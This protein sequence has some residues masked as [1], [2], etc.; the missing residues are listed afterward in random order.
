VSRTGRPLS[1]LHL[2]TFYPPYSFGGDAMYIYRLAHALGDE[3]HHVEV[4]HCLD[5]YHLLHPG[6]PPVG[7]PGHPN[8]V[9]HPL[10]SGWGP[11]SPLASHQSGRPWLK[12]QALRRVLDSRP[13]DVV[14]FHNISLL[15]PRVL[16]LAPAAGRPVKL[17]TT[18]EHWLICPTHVLWK[19]N[20]RPCERPACL[21]CTLMA[22]R[23]PQLWRYTG[24]L[25]REAAHVDRFLAP[26]RFTARMHAERGFPR[27]V[28]HLPYFVDRADED[29][30]SPGPRPHPAPY[31]LF[32]GRLELIKGLQTLIEAFRTVRGADLLVAGTG[33]YEPAL[34]AMAAG[35]PRIRFLGAVPPR[36]LGRLYTH[37]LACVVPSLTIETFGIIIIEAFAR[38]TPVIARD[39]GAL[40]EVVHDSD[41]GLLFR[42]DDELRAALE[43]ILASPGLRERLGENGYR[44]FL[45]HWCRQAHLEQYFDILRTTAAAKY[46]VVP[47]E[48]P[49]GASA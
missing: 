33:T 16:R 39:L 5:A 2:T 48:T 26:S 10:R 12:M 18:H 28:G 31:F 8:V 49:A 3:G 35:D 14:H 42:T 46:G 22:R 25:G 47:W 21:R 45:R 15:G 38:R 40:S 36:E 24:L 44:A 11:L 13:W 9:D 41:G 17:Y 32:V 30:T 6:P 34:R 43:R 27:P 1:F 23:P 19:F 7:F 20:R 29:W 37:A 4:V